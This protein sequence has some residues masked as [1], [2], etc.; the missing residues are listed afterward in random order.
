[1]KRVIPIS[2]TLI[3]LISMFASNSFADNANPP[4]L[5]SVAQTTQG[6]YRP[7]DLIQFKL[8][9]SGGAPQISNSRITGPIGCF[10]PTGD[11]NPSQGSQFDPQYWSITTRTYVISSACPSGTHNI[12]AISVT[13]VT[14]LEDLVFRGPILATPSLQFEVVNPYRQPMGVVQ[15]VFDSSQDKVILND[16]ISVSNDRTAINKISLNTGPVKINLPRLT[17]LGMVI[18]WGHVY[19]PFNCRFIGQR[20][21]SDT[22]SLE[23]FRSGTCNII[24][25]AYQPNG[26]LTFVGRSPSQSNYIFEIDSQKSVSKVEITCTNGK[27]TKKVSGTNPKCPKGYKVKV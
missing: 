14:G 1:M 26:T 19:N 27:T 16:F 12:K 18:V 6:P 17:E 9:I 24:A 25:K 15:P 7:G 21:P 22:V 2:V 5:E 10:L 13:D 4:K 3:C 8:T 23:F 20:F 11:S